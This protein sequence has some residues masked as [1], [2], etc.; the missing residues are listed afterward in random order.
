MDVASLLNEKIF[1]GQEFLTWLWWRS[2][3]EA[4]LQSAQGRMVEVLLGD[5]LVLGPAQ[6]REGARVTVR[7]REASLAEAREGLKRGK[8]VETLRLGL[9]VD[10]EEFWLTLRAADFTI[11]S[12]KL[13]PVRDGGERGLDA[14]GLWLERVALIEMACSGLDD[15]LAAFL[16]ERLDDEGQGL[17][18]RLQA[19]MHEEE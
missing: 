4:P 7:G 17:K 9:I 1:L 15:L 5:H 3:Q 8:L 19:W 2:E 6:G 14:Q 10:N 13:P 18:K 11:S 16:A 12:L